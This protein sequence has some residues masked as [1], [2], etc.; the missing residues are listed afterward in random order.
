VGN[1]FEGDE[2]KLIERLR[3]SVVRECGPE[4]ETALLAEAADMI[5]KL[6]AERDAFQNQC[7]SLKM[8]MTIMR[9]ERDMLVEAM[10]EIVRGSIDD[11]AAEIANEA[12]AKV[13]KP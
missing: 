6:T 8:R 11:E 7:I 3:Y 13:K 9:E 1:K 10:K 12:L 2:M 4:V 5:E